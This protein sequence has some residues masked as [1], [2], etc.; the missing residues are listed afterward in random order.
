MPLD[1]KVR[2]II[3]AEYLIPKTVDFIKRQAAAKPLE[4][5]LMAVA[6]IIYCTA[7][8]AFG[9]KAD[10]TYCSANVRL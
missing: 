10:M 3:D 1:M 5:P 9:G 7:M 2:P 8:S 4:C 6:D